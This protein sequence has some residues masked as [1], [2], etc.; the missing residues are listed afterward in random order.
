MKKTIIFSIFLLGIT[1]VISQLLIIRET[2]INFY[3]NEFF[4]GWVIFCWLFWTGIGSFIL[5]IVFSQ[6]N[7]LNLLIICHLFIGLFL[8]V[9]LP[10]FR[11]A[12]QLLNTSTGQINDL[13]PSLF[14]TL[15]A[16]APLCL[17]LGLQFAAATRF[18]NENIGKETTGKIIGLAYFWETL[19]FALGGFLFAYIFVLLRELDLI[20]ILGWLNVICASIFVFSKKKSF[21]LKFCT[22]AL[23][24]VTSFSLIVS[25][26]IDKFTKSLR[27]PHQELILSKNSQYGNIAVTKTLNQYN[28]YES[29][30]LLGTSGEDPQKQLIHLPL[31]Y[32]QNPK[33]V[34]LIGNGINGTINE[35]LKHNPQK[36][37]YLEIDPLLIETAKE[38]LSPQI[39]EGFLSPKVEIVNVDARN[40]IKATQEK[41][42]LIIVNL[43]NPSTALIN[44]FY[45][46]NFFV[47]AKAK[48]NPEGVFTISTSSLHNYL[49]PEIENLDISVFGALKAVFPYV[50]SLPEENNI[51]IAASQELNYS[52]QEIADRLVQRK[53]ENNWVNQA[54]LLNRLTNDRIKKFLS[55]AESHAVSP[56]QDQLPKTYYYQLAY[57]LSLFHPSA[58]KFFL[59]I[60]KISFLWFVLGLC[61]IF[62]LITILIIKKRK[63][64]SRNF[65]IL[66]LLI[67]GFSLMASEMIL[68]LGFQIFYGN[69]Y[70]KIATIIT[71]L[72][73]GMAMGCYF[74]TEIIEKTKTKA[75]VIIHFSFILVLLLILLRFHFLFNAPPKPLGFVEIIFNLTALI[76]GVLIGGEFPL[77]N[78]FYLENIKNPGKKT[79]IIYGAD[80]F[81]SCLG[82]SLLSIFLMPIFG[83]YNCLF[84]LI[85]L[86][87]LALM[88]YL[89]FRFSP[90]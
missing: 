42:D 71:A 44:R 85:F 59:F 47:E 74:V 87:F 33:Q 89:C 21:V 72:M 39:K 1:S 29:G 9:Q 17:F 32:H 20:S 49:G 15:F 65:L 51:F 64:N 75:I 57:W 14:Y 56:N 63:E 77:I 25:E 70:L 61:L 27:F 6:K 84:F 31:L 16:L 45:T 60:E 37:Y 24:F 66:I 90:N 34:L 67:S 88:F 58:A 83:I 8:I 3:G 78:K 80:L 35:I 38:Y 18:W 12:N 76:V 4:I 82:A 5:G 55:L 36:I 86:N 46:Q 50:L 54:Y 73:I 23:I 40:F 10:L 43:P 68:I 22:I 53:I 41:F 26:K 7:S 13:V 62:L 30:L 52:A 2:T 79:G 48:M 28:F 81:G 19:G 11:F 69:I